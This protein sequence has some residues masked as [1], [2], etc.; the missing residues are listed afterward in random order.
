LNEEERAILITLI[1]N[2]GLSI[3]DV[4]FQNYFSEVKNRL[5]FT[6]ESQIHSLDKIQNIDYFPFVS[7]KAEDLCLKNNQEEN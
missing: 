7:R 4:K 1:H 6:F 5:G 3:D 2:P